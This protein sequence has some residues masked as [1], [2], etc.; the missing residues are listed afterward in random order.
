MPRRDV[1][2]HAIGMYH[3]PLVF[4]V[5]EMLRQARL[6]LTMLMYNT[7]IESLVEQSGLT[8][9]SL[10]SNNLCTPFRNSQTLSLLHLNLAS[11]E[12]SAL[13]EL[14]GLPTTFPS[15]ETLSLRF[16]PLTNLEYPQALM[17]VLTLD[18]SSTLL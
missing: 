2:I 14:S 11:N 16:N 4:I 10:A 18:V 9:L 12:Y 6:K 8:S 17:N 5:S 3:V 7:Q 15:L 13:N 1:S